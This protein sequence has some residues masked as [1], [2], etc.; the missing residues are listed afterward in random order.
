MT[1]IKRAGWYAASFLMGGVVG[2]AIALLYAPESGRHLRKD[3]KKKTNEYIEDGKKIASDTW[4]DA[5]ETAESALE[6]ANDFLNSGMEKI[7]KKTEK[8]KEALKSGYNAFNDE[9]M[10]EKN[11]HNSSKEDSKKH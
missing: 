7:I 3:I 1:S 8:A 10:S 9:R 5:K 6:S 11:Q 4:N 2:G